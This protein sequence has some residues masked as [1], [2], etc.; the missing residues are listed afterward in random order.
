MSGCNLINPEEP[1]PAYLAIDKISVSADYNTQGTSSSNFSDAWIYLDNQI[2]GGFE[3]PTTVPLIASEG[4]HL[5]TIAPGVRADGFEN[6]R[7]IL[8]LFTFFDSTI[9]LKPGNVT[10]LSPILKY[11]EVAQF[12]Y[13][14]DFDDGGIEFERLN[15]SDT[16]FYASAIN[17]YE[18]QYSAIAYLDND[19]K[20]L[21]A[22]SKDGYVLE[23][24]HLAIIEMNYKCTTSF[25]LGLQKSLF[26]GVNV[27]IPF[28]TLYPTSEWKKIYVDLSPMV[29]SIE[30]FDAINFKLLFTAFLDAD[31]TSG[32]I[33]IDN[34]K[35]VY[36]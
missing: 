36:I 14:E 9:Y 15:S 19:R 26:G 2:A 28:L 7:S 22:T 12:K 23:R 10:H 17:P 16:L 3:L 31:K 20:T 27:P 6:L 32:V 35:L 29:N 13:L 34:I 25:N 18:G 24:N 4:N 5:I 21:G 30:N 8:A 33:Q 11:K 1:V